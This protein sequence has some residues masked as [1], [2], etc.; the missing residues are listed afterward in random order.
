MK[1]E[2]LNI[3]TYGPSGSGK[4]FLIST[5]PG[6]KLIVSFETGGTKSL[7]GKENI[8]VYD[9]TVDGNNNELAR[10]R[11]IDKLRHFITQVLPTI[12][13]NYQWLCIDSLTELSQLIVESLEKK[14][15]DKSNTFVLWGEYNKG[16]RAILK[17]FRD[18]RINTYMTCLDSIDKDDSGKRFISFDIN[19]KISNRIPALFD[20]IF[21]LKEFDENNK[22]VRKLIT[23]NYHNIIAKDR[24]GKL[25]LIENANLSEILTKIQGE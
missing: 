4:T 21:Y 20:E 19:G 24:S 16:L 5:L 15:P 13:G 14:Y 10:E 25:A 12:I 6:K 18:V 1:D 7:Q 17:D 3:V 9:C 23:G 22:P 11:R 2:H 8:D